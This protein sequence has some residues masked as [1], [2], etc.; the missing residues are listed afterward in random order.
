MSDADIADLM[1]KIYQALKVKARQAL[2]DDE[3]EEGME[4]V[5]TKSSGPTRV[6][7]IVDEMTREQRENFLRDF[8]SSDDTGS[9]G[10][11][12]DGVSSDPGPNASVLQNDAPPS[13][14]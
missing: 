8:V 13:S 12:I 3:A 2:S 14:V 6:T 9:S 11:R 4:L 7:L 1:K 10:G 5:R